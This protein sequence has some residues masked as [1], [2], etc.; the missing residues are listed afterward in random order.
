MHTAHHFGQVSSHL[1]RLLK[2][3]IHVCLKLHH[4]LDRDQLQ[5]CFIFR[6]YLFKQHFIELSKFK[7]QS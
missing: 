5:K 7:L 6:P 4:F 2:E 1:L 3:A